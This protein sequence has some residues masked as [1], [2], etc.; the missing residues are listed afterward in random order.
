MS[1]QHDKNKHERDC[2]SQT[3]TLTLQQLDIT[4]FLIG[5]PF[6]VT[7]QATRRGDKVTL[8]IPGINLTFPVYQVDTAVYPPPPPGYPLGGFVDTVGGFLP[9]EF[10]PTSGL[11]ISFFIGADGTAEDPSYVGYVDFHGRLQISGLHDFPVNAGN[12]VSL[13]ASVTYQIRPTPNPR[14]KNFVISPGFSNAS[15]FSGDNSLNFDFGDYSEIKSA[16]RNGVLYAIWA[17]NST[18][19][20]GNNPSQM[21]PY[22]NQAVAKI[23]V[24]NNARN[25]AVLN[26]SNLTASLPQTFT[27][28]EGSAAIDPTNPNQIAVVYQQRQSSR[29]PFGLSRSFDGGQTWTTQLIG[30]PGTALPTPMGSDVH[31]AFDRFGGMWIVA[32]QYVGST[33]PFIYVVHSGDFGNTFEIAYAIPGL[34]LADFY[35]PDLLPYASG[36]DFGSIGIGPDATN[37]AQDV[38]WVG[39]DFALRQGNTTYQSQLISL[40]VRSKTDFDTTPVKTYIIPQTSTNE[41]SYID[42]DNNGAVTLNLQQN[43]VIGTNIDQPVNN[44]K[45]YTYQLPHGLADDT[46]LGPQAVVQTATGDLLVPGVTTPSHL[47]IGNV[48]PAQPHRGIQ[49]PALHQLAIDKSFS[50]PGR[51]YVVFNDRSWGDPFGTSDFKPYLTWSDDKGITWS[52]PIIVA[53]NPTS[54]NSQFLPDIAVDPSTGNVAVTWYD[55]R[56]DPTNV[57]VRLWGVVLNATELVIPTNPSPSP[58]PKPKCKSKAKPKCQSKSGV[59][60]IRI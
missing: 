53:D 6:T 55:T 39:Y 57:N 37:L 11:P 26:V 41:Y 31:V 34:P 47:P 43:D 52:P 33:R 29:T 14:V 10:R 15:N 42:V 20:P 23:S 4:A 12:F 13:P 49:S 50:H 22:K 59:T 46:I 58:S 21:Q 27:Y 28:A 54:T 32:T 44:V 60:I 5:Q 56:G 24:S 3:L 45:I 38:V 16:F 18:Q 36:L 2:V 17:D 35:P 19:L 25:V 51:I 30:G 48:I 1:F 40:R 7:V 9:P 8:T